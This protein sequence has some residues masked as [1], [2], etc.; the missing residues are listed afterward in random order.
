MVLSKY[1]AFARIS[2]THG[3]YDRGELYGRM[4][5]FVV[6]LGVFS[7]LWRAARR[8]GAGRLRPTRRVSCGIWRAPNGSC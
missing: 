5:F 4:A 1:V 8:G 7:S 6:I 2:A 3:R